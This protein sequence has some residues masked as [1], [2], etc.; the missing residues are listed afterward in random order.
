MKDDKNNTTQEL[1]DIFSSKDE[2][3]SSRFE[4]NLKKECLK[5]I[6]GNNNNFTFSIMKKSS[7]LLLLGG[8]FVVLL[9]AI[10]LPIT[11]IMLNKT[12]KNKTIDV[13]AKLAE[14]N[15]TQL[16]VNTIKNNN[17]N[18][19]SKSTNSNQR[20]EGEDA[21]LS[22]VNVSNSIST[23]PLNVEIADFNYSEWKE[24]TTIGPAINKC[25]ILGYSSELTDSLVYEGYSYWDN[26]DYS[27][28]NYK[29]ILKT[30]DGKLVNYSLTNG[31]TNFTYRGGKYA[32]QEIT[33]NYDIDDLDQ[34]LVTESD[35]AE[36]IIAE[37]STGSLSPE[38]MVEMYFG[39]DAKLINYELYNGEYYFVVQWTQEVNCS[40][41]AYLGMPRTDIGNDIDTSKII[42]QTWIRES[43]Q[44]WS[45][46]EQ[47]LEK[48][49]PENL[50]YR[51]E[52]QSTN[53]KVT[54]D[55]VS[56]KFDNDY[57]DVNV[58]E[59]TLDY[60]IMFGTEA[61]KSSI[62]KKLTEDQVSIIIPE[63]TNLDYL[64]SK[65]IFDEIY[66]SYGS[67]LCN[68][69]FYPTGEY[70]TKLKEYHCA[71]YL[72]TS[73]A[74]ESDIT[75]NNP[76][77]YYLVSFEDDENKII[78]IQVY[79]KELLNE[80]T[81]EEIINKLFPYDDN[82]ASFE[83][84]DYSYQMTPVT[85]LGSKQLKLGSNTITVTVYSQSSTSTFVGENNQ[86]ITETY[87]STFTIFTYDGATY[88]VNYS[89][90]GTETSTD[91]IPTE[92]KTYNTSNETQRNQLIALIDEM[93]KRV[94][95]QMEGELEDNLYSN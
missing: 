72:N 86:E 89:E 3:P 85:K 9:I 63:N 8:A 25:N 22:T 40:S 87:S 12:P 49:S 31:N 44:M 15:L 33:I 2:Q 61:E 83:G 23:I 77:Y 19:L 56:N 70:G 60:S 65:N 29:Y 88:V 93:Y 26:E 78:N 28:S 10:G 7:K 81:E 20:A 73:T 13:N 43:D 4:K 34:E 14:T 32:L 58:K 16:L 53:K 30:G 27:N 62:K 74:E 39:K 48:V 45:K 67:E 6:N 76:E 21:M 95:T 42:F 1:L 90:V 46:N 91:L 66:F 82:I 5:N 51:S 64:Y 80:K 24:K 41:D 54:Y 50:I 69:D 92:Y 11:F 37:N 38:E 47:Y 17:A 68:P 57:K 52:T 79:N 18:L 71:G 94:K 84:D 55:E 59:I 75:L 36:E 35:T